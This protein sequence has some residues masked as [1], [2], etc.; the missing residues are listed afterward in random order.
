M[1]A[2]WSLNVEILE[3]YYALLEKLEAK[4]FR[5]LTYEEQEVA[6]LELMKHKNIK[7]IG[8]TELNKEEYI[9]ELVSKGKKILN[10][11]EDGYKFYKPKDE[12]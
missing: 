12:E 3:E 6:F 4:F 1:K 9:N 5:P 11:D 7:P 10:I 8:H 2:L